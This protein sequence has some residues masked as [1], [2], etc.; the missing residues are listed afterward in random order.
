MPKLKLF[1]PGKH[2]VCAIPLVFYVSQK[3]NTVYQES[4]RHHCHEI[5]LRWLFL[6]RTK[7]L[8]AYKEEPYSFRN[9]GETFIEPMIQMIWTCDKLAST[10]FAKAVAEY[11]HP[12]EVAAGLEP[13]KVTKMEEYEH[14]VLLEADPKWASNSLSMSIWLVLMRATITFREG[15]LKWESHVFS[16]SYFNRL[17]K[18][19]RLNKVW[20]ILPKL[21]AHKFKFWC[22][23]QTW[24]PYSG[25]YSQL[26]TALPD[27]ELGEW[28]WKNCWKEGNE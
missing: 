13:T 14:M 6:E 12:I 3:G 9:P 23:R 25:V 7:K 18:V 2:D 21:I 16:G 28:M 26:R 8:G 15:T 27:N 5:L 17:Y 1:L 22:G 11:I 19:S 24:S 10:L 20:D 4:V